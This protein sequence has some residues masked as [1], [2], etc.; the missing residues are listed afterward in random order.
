MHKILQILDRR[1]ER[2]LEMVIPLTVFNVNASMRNMNNNTT[3][4]CYVNTLP[5][6][7]CI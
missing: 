4:D 7:V 3:K 5:D 2:E 6:I 1:F